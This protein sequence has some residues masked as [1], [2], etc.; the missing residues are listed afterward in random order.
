[1]MTRVV[2]VAVLLIVTIALRTGAAAVDCYS[3]EK[4]C[5]PRAA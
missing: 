1:M 4:G 2:C 3:G 5:V